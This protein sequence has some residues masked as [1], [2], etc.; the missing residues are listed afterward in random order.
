MSCCFSPSESPKRV[1]SFEDHFMQSSSLPKPSNDEGAKSQTAT[2]MFISLHV[3]IE[4]E[5]D[6]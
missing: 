1:G 6:R 4:R 2:D 5:R 3:V